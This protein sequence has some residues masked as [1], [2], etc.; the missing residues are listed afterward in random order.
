[1]MKKLLTGLVLL[2]ILAGF[3]VP[4]SGLIGYINRQALVIYDTV[5]SGDEVEIRALFDG[6][7]SEYHI[8]INSP[9]G[10]GSVCMSMWN[11]IR[12]LQESGA[13]ITTEVSGMAASA[14]AILWMTGDV[15]IVHRNDLVMFHGVQM[16]DQVSGQPL[17]ESALDEYDKKIINTLNEA[18]VELMTPFVGE[19]KARGMLVGET[20]LTGREAYAMGLATILK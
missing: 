1:M 14:G 3:T 2:A 12:D 15:R 19:Q 13:K 7:E 10:R 16:I 11:H 17:P 4:A 5:T 8:V 9:G 18:M 6:Q 20:W